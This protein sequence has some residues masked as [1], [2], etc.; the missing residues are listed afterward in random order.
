M[1]IR[2]AP[3]LIRAIRS[4]PGSI[5]IQVLGPRPVE[6]AE[7]LRLAS[8]DIAA[9]DAGWLSAPGLEPGNTNRPTVVAG[10][11]PARPGPV[12]TIDGGHV[13]VELL[14]RV[15]DIIERH[16]AR[17]GISDA[18]LTVPAAPRLLNPY[19]GLSAVPNV[20]VLRIFPSPL[21]ARQGV[22]TPPPAGWLEAAGRW[23]DAELPGE[24]VTVADREIEFDLARDAALDYLRGASERHAMAVHVIAGGPPGPVAL[25]QG[26]FGLGNLALAVAG[27]HTGGPELVATAGRL[28]DLAR[29]LAPECSQ[30]FVTFL[31]TL[32]HN[33]S[34]VPPAP[35][36]YEPLDGGGVSLRSAHPSAVVQAC[37]ELVF[38]AYPFQV[39][40][41]G[42]ARR[43]GGL[44]RGGA[45]LP[46][47]SFELDIGRLEDWLPG[48]AELE[49][50][51]ACGRAALAPCLLSPEAVAKL[52][53]ERWSSPSGGR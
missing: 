15:P 31:P 24:Y 47:G 43:L 6:A 8:G 20:A 46:A 50:L 41:P 21:F 9:L 29:Q 48:S 32:A 5:V 16:L 19:E 10:V 1:P 12:L 40:G 52:S 25:I 37:D 3:R 22:W 45:P 27:E 13:P 34:A 17:L 23:L 51:R 44:P 42:H 28:R 38:D 39:L 14:L 18:L 49:A 2:T 53:E 36:V 26:H 11:T 7:A 33:L 30:A 4:H 35:G